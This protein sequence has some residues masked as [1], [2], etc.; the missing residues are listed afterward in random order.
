[1]DYGRGAFRVSDDVRCRGVDL[2]G[3]GELVACWQFPS[4]PLIAIQLG[5]RPWAEVD[6][7]EASA[8]VHWALRVSGADRSVIGLPGLAGRVP[9]ELDDDA[10]L[11][12]AALDHALDAA[13][14]RLGV[15]GE[16]LSPRNV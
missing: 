2:A 16:T 7:F 9:D 8:S 5:G 6:Y 11:R 1:M 13:A 14:D 12:V 3:L 4:S 10:D 15:R